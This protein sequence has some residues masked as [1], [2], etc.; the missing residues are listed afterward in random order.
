MWFGSGRVGWEDSLFVSLLSFIKTLARGVVL[1]Y[2]SSGQWT[3]TGWASPRRTMWR[4]E[5]APLPLWVT[6]SFR[7]CGG[8]YL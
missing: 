5:P 7:R 8:S 2:D 6:H 1:E 3:L 4:V